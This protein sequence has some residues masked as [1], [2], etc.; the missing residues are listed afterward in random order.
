MMKNR[1]VL[2]LNQ[3]ELYN[4]FMHEMYEVKK[5]KLEKKIYMNWTSCLFIYLFNPLA[6]E[7][8]KEFWIPDGNKNDDDGSFKA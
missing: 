7:S 5:I 2:H 6:S 1:V 4:D 3:S 8:V